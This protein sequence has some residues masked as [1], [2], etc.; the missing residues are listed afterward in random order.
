MKILLANGA[1]IDHLGNG[2]T[3]IHFAIM[4]NKQSIFDTLLNTNPDLSLP[5][6]DSLLHWA[7]YMGNMEIAEKLI[8]YGVDVD[9][10]DSDEMSS[11]HTAIEEIEE[12]SDSVEAT[13]W[14]LGKRASLKI[15]N[16]DGNNPLECALKKEE[17]KLD[18]IKV[19]TFHQHEI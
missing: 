3:P 4:F 14:L 15:R 12:A 2:D 19:I 5:C 18:L 11:I 13:Q 9:S 7:V 6:F 10:K 1:K 16:L 8:S 17:K